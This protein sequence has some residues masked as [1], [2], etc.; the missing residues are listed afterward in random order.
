MSPSRHKVI[1]TVKDDHF[2]DPKEVKYTLYI[3][4]TAPPNQTSAIDDVF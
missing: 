3:D 2:S 4:V 1:F